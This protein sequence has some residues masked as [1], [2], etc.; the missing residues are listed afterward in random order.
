MN[1]KS[2]VESIALQ[3]NCSQSES[4]HFINTYQA[5]MVEELGHQGEF[6][7]P[8]IGSLKRKTRAARI[9][10]NPRTGETIQIPEKQVVQFKTTAPLLRT[11]NQN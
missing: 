2:L 3:M 5:V 11:L 10:R 6:T 4:L 7:L 9:G 1:K 8:G